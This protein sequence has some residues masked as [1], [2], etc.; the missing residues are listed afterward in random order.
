MTKNGDGSKTLYLALDHY[1]WKIVENRDIM[2][3]KLNFKADPSLDITGSWTNVF[4][5]LKDKEAG[6]LF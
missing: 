4:H 6:F 3:D 2:L 5:S 1:D